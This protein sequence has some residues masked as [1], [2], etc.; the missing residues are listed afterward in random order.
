[1]DR[2]IANRLARLAFGDSTAKRREVNDDAQLR[3]AVDLL[4]K[5]SSQKDLF[6]IAEHVRKP[7]S[8]NP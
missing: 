8:S 7:D 5:G 6:V 4:K 2:L 3:T 1:M